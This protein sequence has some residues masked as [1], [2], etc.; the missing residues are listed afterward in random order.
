MEL[1]QSSPVE[2]LS[3]GILQP[4]SRYNFLIQLT[5]NGKHNVEL[6]Q[7]ANQIVAIDL[8]SEMLDS[9]AL[10]HKTQRLV[11]WVEDDERCTVMQTIRGLQMQAFG[12]VKLNVYL[13]NGGRFVLE[14]YS[15]EGVSVEA[16]QHSLFSY[17][18]VDD[19]LSLTAFMPNPHGDSTQVP[20]H[21]S[22]LSSQ[23][24]STS[25]KLLQLRF[26]DFNHDIFNEPVL[27]DDLMQASVE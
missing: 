24:R 15:Y 7:F 25:M 17:T 27:V 23:Q 6:Q 18:P 16:M 8:G 1:Q 4:K 22:V 19:K 2:G 9:A 10:V 21:G 26:H 11:A 13:I 3:T 20:I 12:D 14:Q 5:E